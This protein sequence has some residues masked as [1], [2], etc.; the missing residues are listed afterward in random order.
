MAKGIIALDIDGTLVSN[1]RP[2]TQNLC[3]VLSE[4]HK[5]G[6]ELLFAT[7]RTLQWG[8]NHLVALPCPFYLAAYNGAVVYSFPEKQ[9]LRSSFLQ[10]SDLLSLSPFIEQFGALIYEGLGQ[11]RIFYTPN[12]FSQKMLAHVH[13]RRT[14]QNEV[15]VEISSLED[16]PEC[17]YASVRVFAMRELAEVIGQ[18]IAARTSLRAP[19]MKDALNPKIFV[20]QVTSRDASKG[21]ALTFLQQKIP[22]KTIAAG[23]DMNDIDML[24]R[25]TVAIAMHEAPVEV[26]NVASIIAPPFFED[27]IIAP[28]REAVGRLW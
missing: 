2:L 4:Y 3:Q 1:H 13:A 11:E 22:V 26:K 19:S 27:C 24:Q 5:D 25:A 18:T 17:A 21:Q 28:L 15:F 6:F 14:R 20:V 23:D 7:G 8:M 10:L 9:V 16:L 12:M